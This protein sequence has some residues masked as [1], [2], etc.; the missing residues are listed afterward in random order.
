[1]AKIIT[2]FA[3]SPTGYL[4][5]GSVRSALFSYL[6][7]KKNGGK[8][9]LR[10]ED[11]DKTRSKIE[12]EKDIIAGFQTL[13]LN[14]D[15]ETL[16]RQSDHIAVYSALIKKLIAED[17]AYVS[18]EEPKEE[19]ERSEVIRLRNPNKKV[20]FTDL[21]HGEVSVDT[22]DLGDF[23]IAKS[24]DE[25]IFHFANVVDDHEMGITHVIRGE[26]H[27]SNTPRQILIQEAL[28]YD[29]LAYAHIPLVLAR[30]R[31]KLS[32]RQGSVSLRE[33]LDKGYLSEALLNY[34]A[35]LGWHPSH[36]KEIFTMPELI[37]TFELERVQKR[38]AIWNF[39]KLD[40]VN[41]EHLKMNR[42][43]AENKIQEVLFKTLNLNPG[44]VD[45]NVL[46][47]VV[48]IVFERINKFSDINE[49]V[50]NNEVQYFFEEPKWQKDGFLWKGQG[51]FHEIADKLSAV[52]KLLG[53]MEGNYSKETIKE[54]IWPYAEKEGRGFVLWPFRY[55]LSGLAKSPDPF[56]IAEILKKETTVT[57]LK[58]A[59]NFLT[60]ES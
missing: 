19:G 50:L 2:R 29:K 58:S 4:H 24:V 54:T 6:Y 1:M 17:K 48:N 16:Y 44:T 32:K 36:D 14:W 9:F 30:D 31:S 45:K 53:A 7:A 33:F 28:G 34:L 5:I 11:T 47:A 42:E 43:T 55:A 57:R 37:S 25:P 18:K 51:A 38:G 56:V 60:N 23:V 13:G 39:E 49:L 10:I 52:E 8:Y 20:T 46:D 12:Y 27:L 35:L 41:K 26:E 21:V 40:W 15:N 59:I 3:P 22:T